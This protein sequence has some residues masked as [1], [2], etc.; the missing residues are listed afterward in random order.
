MVRREAPT[1]EEG[2]KEGRGGV[3]QRSHS[4]VVLGLVGGEGGG[5]GV[6]SG[7]KRERERE[8]T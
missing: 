3:L 8:I 5:R 7:T 1:G 2:D 4:A 6:H